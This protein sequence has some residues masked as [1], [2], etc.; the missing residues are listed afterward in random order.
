MDHAIASMAARGH[1]R[2]VNHLNRH[3]S[4]FAATIAALTVIDVSTGPSLWVHW[5]VLGWGAGL[6]LHAL[7]IMRHERAGSL[8]RRR[9]FSAPS[10]ATL[11][12]RPPE[13]LP[14]PPFETP[15]SIP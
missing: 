13:L 8:H 11:K 7:L 1:E 12:S 10:L 9:P 15:D 3:M 6:G 2:A 14:D 5:V 4:I